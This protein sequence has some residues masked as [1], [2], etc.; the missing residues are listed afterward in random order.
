MRPDSSKPRRPVMRFLLIFLAIILCTG[1][2]TAG[3]YVWKINGTLDKVAANDTGSVPKKEL[4]KVKPLTILLLGKDSRPETGTLNTDVIMAISLNPER[5]TATFV[6]LP[7]DTYTKISDYKDGHKA[8]YY[9]AYAYNN[10]RDRVYEE[11]KHV[12]SEVFGTEIDYVSVIDFKTFEDIVDALGG[13]EVNVD[14]DMRYVDNADGTNIDLK[15]GFQELDG[16]NAL[17][18]VRYRKSNRGTDPSS[19]FE[20][21]RRQQQLISAVVDKVKSPTIVL[22]GGGIL[23]A[24]GDNVDTDIPK[25]QLISLI[26]TYA[27]ISND[28]IKY[29]PLE[30]VWRSPYTYI[31]EQ[32]FDQAVL[33]LQAQLR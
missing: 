13:V 24:I 7:R 32:A 21:N 33:E 8:N 22:K 9:Y 31:D 5:K 27:G 2:L 4:A 1:G 20:R 6:S 29:I 28:K 10:E 18:F 17:D 23:D 16:K 26:Q 19:D 25:N 15:A 11:V 14:Q 30:G 3:Y 12:Y